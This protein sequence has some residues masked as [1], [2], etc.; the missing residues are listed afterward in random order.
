VLGVAGESKSGLRRVWGGVEA[1]PSVGADVGRSRCPWCRFSVWEWYEGSMTVAGLLGRGEESVWR[2]GLMGRT[3]EEAER[4][5]RRGYECSH[6]SSSQRRPG[7]LVQVLSRRCTRYV[8][9]QSLASVHHWQHLIPSDVN[10]KCVWRR[11]P[12]FKTFVGT[13]CCTATD[14]II[15]KRHQRYRR[16]NR[17]RTDG[18]RSV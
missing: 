1:L 11:L 18:K 13:G 4:R 10:K 17:S 9:C 3:V 7:C 6:R 14:S 15:R 8:R 5:I 16:V 2:L 12:G